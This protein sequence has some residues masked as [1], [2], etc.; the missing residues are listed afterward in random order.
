MPKYVPAGE[1][2]CTLIWTNTQLTKN[3]TVQ[4]GVKNIDNSDLIPQT[5]ADEVY[6]GLVGDDAGHLCHASAMAV[7]WSFLGVEAATPVEGGYLISSHLVTVFGTGSD[8]N[9]PVNTSYLVKK[10]TAFGGRRNRGRMF[11]PPIMAGLQ[12][13][14]NGL[15]SGVGPGFID[16]Q[17]AELLEHLTNAGI[18]PT[19]FHDRPPLSTI[20]VA[21]TPVTGFSAV[22]VAATQ[23]RRLR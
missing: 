16:A 5:A 21:S 1:C 13:D 12:T 19:I 22:G 18:E 6:D 15:W 17:F 4:L 8:N 14:T 3:V 10:N 7:G 23:R 11:L 2:D 20:P 9:V